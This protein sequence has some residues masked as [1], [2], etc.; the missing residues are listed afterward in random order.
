MPELVAPTTRLHPS[1]LS[2]RREW[3]PGA[4]LHGSGL[5]PDDD[6]ETAGGFAAWVD[7]LV[8][9]SD[10]STPVEAN[11]VHATYWWIAEGDEYL[12][13]ITLRHRLNDFLLRVGGHVGYHVRPSARQQGLAGWALGEVLG[14]ARARGIERALVTCDDTN[15]ASAR[16]IERNGGVLENV[17]P[18]TE[19]G[20]I[21]RYWIDLR[22]PAPVEWTA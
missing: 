10:E 11:R 3:E 19:F 8:R 2:A 17:V 4:T 16:T 14:V 22:I 20:T 6:A 15:L 5:H 12:G 9:Q 7:R 18:D 1:W 13:A 21:R